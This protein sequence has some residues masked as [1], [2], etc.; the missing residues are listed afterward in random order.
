[1]SKD[2][3]KK[4]KKEK[5]CKEFSKDHKKNSLLLIN[6]GINIEENN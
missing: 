1:L 3:D 6:S 4:K 5:K 2:L